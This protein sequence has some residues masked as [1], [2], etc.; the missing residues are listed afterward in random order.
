[1]A[2]PVIMAVSGIMNIAMYFLLVETRGSKILEN[3]ARKLTLQTGILHIADTGENNN[4]QA[5]LLQL[6][7]ATAS[8]PIIFLVTEPVVAGIATWAA[9]LLVESC[10]LCLT[11]YRLYCRWGV[12]YLLFSSIPLVYAQYN[13]SVGETGTILVTVII[14]AILGIFAA[15]WQDHLYHQ[16]ARRTPHGRAPPE[17]RLYGA[18]VSVWLELT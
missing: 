6:V 4:Q 5:S 10:Y 11:P 2:N 13:F 14:G 15:K 3:R 9:L 8:R 18:C 12:V 16:D 1:M 7:K 17:S